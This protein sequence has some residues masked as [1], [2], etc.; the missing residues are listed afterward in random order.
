[1][2]PAQLKNCVELAVLESTSR[3]NLWKKSPCAPLE[4]FIQNGCEM[5]VGGTFPITVTDD[6]NITLPLMRCV[7]IRRE[8]AHSLT[9]I[10][11]TTTTSFIQRLI[12]TSDYLSHRPQDSLTQ[13]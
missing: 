8:K 6:V 10:T 3:G 4:S 11:T 1:M 13:E 2:V 9:A 5:K 7:L 12:L